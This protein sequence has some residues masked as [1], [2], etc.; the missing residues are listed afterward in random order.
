MGG[1]HTTVHNIC[2][3]S[4]Y[5]EAEISSDE[6]KNARIELEL[7]LPKSSRVARHERLV[8]VNIH[9]VTA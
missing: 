8:A 7:R 4:I 1:A 5:L 9:V 2:S 6:D 3:R